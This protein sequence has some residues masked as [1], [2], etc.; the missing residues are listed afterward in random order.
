MNKFLQLAAITAIALAT[1]ANASAA[2][3]V[4]F[5]NTEKMSDVPRDKSEREAMESELTDHFKRLAA[6]LPAGQ[7]LKVD[8]LDIDLAGDV[9]PRISIRDIRVF[10]DRADWPRM[11][12]RFSI[13]QDGKV[14]KSGERSLGDVAYMMGGSRYGNEL[15]RYEKKML[16]TW[17]RQETGITR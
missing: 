11:H 12:L 14:L 1:A 16:D 10:R 9:F 7:E 5:A 2:A 4:T 8:V 15:Y 17:F 6:K 13:E 3:T